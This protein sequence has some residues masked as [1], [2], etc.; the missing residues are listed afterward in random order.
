MNLFVS[1]LGIHCG[2]QY[3]NSRNA[4]GVSLGTVFFLF[5]GVFACM[6]MMI[7]LS[8]SFEM[9]MAPFLGFIL[10]G[11]VGLFV[12]LGAGNPSK[13]IA[14]S[15]ILAPFFTFFAI[16]SF[17]MD[18]NLSVFLVTVCTY[19]FTTAAMLIPALYEFDFALGGRATNTES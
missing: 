5:L 7:M 9:Q 12:A 1:V 8:S 16:T 3:A 18:K 4:I 17:L 14:A 6:I 10:G 2:M 11:G 19:G 15:S 13:A